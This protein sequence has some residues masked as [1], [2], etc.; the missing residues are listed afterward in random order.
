MIQQKI[1]L[2]LIL[3]LL[4]GNLL[5]SP[6]TK[7]EKSKIENIIY[8]DDGNTD[9]PWDGSFE[10]PYQHVQ[11][12]VDN[13]SEGDTVFVF[14]GSYLEKIMVRKPNIKLIGEDQNTTFINNSGSGSPDYIVLLLSNNIQFSHF[15]VSLTNGTCMAIQLK[16]ATYCNISF[17][18][19]RST[20]AMYIDNSDYNLI[21]NNKIFTINSGINIAN[22]INTNSSKFNLIKGNYLTNSGNAN[23]SYNCGVSLEKGARYNTV[24][25]NVFEDCQEY[26]IFSLESHDNTIEKNLILGNKN[27]DQTG[28][29]FNWLH[30]PTY[31]GNIVQYNIIKNCTGCGIATMTDGDTITDNLLE[32]DGYG[33][34]IGFGPRNTIIS[35]NTVRG[36]DV[37][38]D[39]WY[40]DRGTIL[41]GNLYENNIEAI[42]VWY[43]SNLT[44][45][46]NTFR[47]NVFGVNCHVANNNDFLRNT[48]QSN[49]I[50]VINQIS[51]NH[52]M[53][54]YWDR[55]RIL[56][57]PLFGYLPFIQYDWRPAL[58]PN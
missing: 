35:N 17:V 33:F 21:Y 16:G 3:F 30:T 50:N 25:E 5:S 4:V 55:P 29:Y 42:E 38:Q 39:I 13:A 52:W 24:S 19:I 45:T 41:E 37:G 46:K 43:C 18:I 48:F 31:V 14:S 40:A 28:I 58:Q 7:S 51:R 20:W 53:Q 15:T 57:K 56:P 2:F 6:I 27:K 49:T 36:C 23:L 10:H 11:N 54:N 47:N 8:V 9:G 1:S 12:G 32:N 44:I 26:A 34:S 22:F